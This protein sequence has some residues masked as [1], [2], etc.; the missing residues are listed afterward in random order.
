V[1]PSP[2]TP[3]TPQVYVVVA[4]DTIEIIA[5]RFGVTV[6]ALLELNPLINPDI[7]IPGQELQLPADA[8]DSGP[9]S[10]P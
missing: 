2:V 5:A 3:V 7:I 1:P 10:A 8:V 4:G 6:T 9:P